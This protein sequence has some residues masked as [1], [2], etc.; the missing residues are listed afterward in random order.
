MNID[1]HQHFWRVSRG[2]YGWMSP[3]MP[4]LYRDY[5]PADLAPLLQAAEIDCTILVQAAQT[6]AETEFLLELADHTPFVAGVVGWLE[7]DDDGFPGRLER[8]RQNSKFVSVRPMLQDLADDA[9]ILRPRVLANLKYLAS[10]DFPFEF[11]T[12]PRHLPHV[13]SALQQVPGLRAVIDHLSKPP[14]G[15]GELEPWRALLRRVAAFPNLSCKV[16]GMVT[17]AD[18]ANWT[19]EDL[20]PYVDHVIDSFG[21]DRLLFGSDWPVALQA[22]TY[23][24]VVN[25][26]RTLLGARLDAAGMAAAFGGNA[27]RFY[28]LAG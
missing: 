19:T 8:F 9:Y 7:L 20:R 17:E 22:A 18:H 1:A 13:E 21:P 26:T 10:I 2:D 12:F 15:S 25:A 4:I 27:K 3:T 6:E 11:L 14:I 23:S 5:L 24:D 16:S 28:G